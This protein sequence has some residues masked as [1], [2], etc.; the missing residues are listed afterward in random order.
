M[1][2][3]GPLLSWENQ[4]DV[5][6]VLGG[7]CALGRPVRIIVQMIGDLRRPEASGVAIVE[8]ALDRLAE[9]RGAAGGI[10]FPSWEKHQR[11][12]HGHMRMLGRR[13]LRPLQRNDVLVERSD[14]ILNA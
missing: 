2:E 1:Q 6:P 12:T 3:E 4:V 5:P 13:L 9:A 7:G 8:I 14:I 11:A 10:D